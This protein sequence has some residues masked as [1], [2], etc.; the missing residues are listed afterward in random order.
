MKGL[1]QRFPYGAVLAFF[2]L[3][4]VAAHALPVV[5][6]AGGDNTAASIQG[7][8]DDFRAFVGDPNNGN[9]PGPL[10]GGRREINWDGGGA[11]T[12]TVSGTPFAGFLNNRGALFNTPGTGFIQASPDDLALQFA[13]PTYSSTFSAFSPLRLF[14]PIDSNITD[15]TFFIPGTAG[16]VPATVSGFGAIFTDVDILGSTQLDFFDIHSNSLGSFNVAAGTVPDGSFSF[17]GVAFDAGERIGRVRI[18]SGNSAL[19]PNDNPPD[20][21]IAAMDDFI[22]AEPQAIIPEPSTLML[23]GFGLIVLAASVRRRL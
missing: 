13:N 11:V 3:L 20:V 23:L 4:P 16:T 10:P 2:L 6:S 14:T 7:A 19:G 5:F 1:I 21:D 22:H 17:L 9:A 15:V 18:T 12:P 8:V